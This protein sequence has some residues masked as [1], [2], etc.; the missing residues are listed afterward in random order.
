[1]ALTNIDYDVR[2][3]E[4]GLNVYFIA[5][6]DS[7][8]NIRKQT[9][10][11]ANPCCNGYS[12][13]K[14]FTVTA[15]GMMYD[16]GLLT[17]QTRVANILGEYIP[18]DADPKWQKVTLHNLMLHYVGY[19]QSNLLDIDA[20]D[21]TQYGSTD[22]LKLAFSAPLPHEPG[23]VHKYTDAA[24][25]ILSRVVAKVG[26]VEMAEMLRPIFMETMKFKEWARRD[27]I[28]APRT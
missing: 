7:E 16:R 4:A 12:M 28:C 1:M 25:Y 15:I 18:S 10:V 24:Y 2:A 22:Y 8:G 6:G 17:P 21:A 9:C 14:A 23:T 5:E 11:P 27:F 19:D 13:A 20:Q 3:R 26:G